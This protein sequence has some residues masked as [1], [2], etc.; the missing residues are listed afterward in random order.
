MSSQI[1]EAYLQFMITI[2]RMVRDD[3][4]MT[5]DDAFVQEEMSRVMDLESDVAKV[6]FYN[7]HVPFDHRSMAFHQILSQT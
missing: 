6:C 3:K 2:A 4:N 1:R 5:K 7:A